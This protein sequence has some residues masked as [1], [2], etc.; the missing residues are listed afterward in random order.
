MKNFR[1]HFR[2]NSIRKKMLLSSFI[3]ITIMLITS[4]YTFYN[5]QQFV[6]KMNYM[7]ISNRELNELSKSIDTLDSELLSYLTTKS[8]DSFDKFK[9]DSEIFRKKNDSFSKE[10]SYDNNKI[11][12]TDLK[13]LID[14]Y[15][16]AANEAI[17]ARRT[18]DI[19][20][21]NS[22]YK[23]AK[24]ISLYIIYYIDKLNLNQF[25]QNTNK[26]FYMSE[27]LTLLKKLNIV[28]IVDSFLLNALLILYFTNKISV[29]IIKL[30]DS[31]EEISRGNFDTKDVSLDCDGEVR[32]MSI[33]FNN[34]KNNIKEYIE[35]LHKQAEMESN[36]MDEKVQ[37]LKMKNL[38]KNA[39]LKALQSQ[40]NPHFL[41]NTLNAGVQLAMM[42]D[43]ERTGLFLENV[44]SL[45]R[46]NLRKMNDLISL[47]DEIENLKNYIFI[48]ET[49][50][51]DL[52]KFEFNIDE[53]VINVKMPPMI[54][55]P[56]VENAC[57]H[58]LGNSENGGIIKIIAK[59]HKNMVQ[60]IIKDN[61]IGINK[62]NINSILKLKNL[63]ESG[64]EKS[65][66]G[67]S[68]GIGLENVIQRMRLFSEDDEVIKIESNEGEGTE[69]IISLKLNVGDQNV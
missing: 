59:Q 8:T 16:F 43:A 37:N 17:K 6:K 57:I 38:L 36:L 47:R 39:E 35:E 10:I 28:I 40:I 69:I 25:Q 64:K 23:S 66:E 48:L 62:D 12:L 14:N 56:L 9:K 45:F 5:S 50:F 15:L 41:F 44:A 54:L 4:G 58:G 55:Q 3:L 1:N 2:V 67:H 53:K 7:F 68:T 42:E 24:N 63:D 21:Y 46:Y 51:G 61:G 49:R 18:G 33:T 22:K 30:A 19:G 13:N 26:Y 29:P 31:A 65:K 52:I 20:L 34:M 60:I 27:K 32:V 11:M